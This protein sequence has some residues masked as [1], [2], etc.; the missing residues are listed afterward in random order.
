MSPS[1]YVRQKV[2]NSD[3]AEVNENEDTE[4]QAAGRGETDEGRAER[5][6]RKV[7]GWSHRRDGMLSPFRKAFSEFNKAQMK[8][9]I[10]AFDDCKGK[11]KE[12]I[13]DEAV[14]RKIMDCVGQSYDTLCNANAESFSDV[15]QKYYN[16]KG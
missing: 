11:V 14:V 6:Q 7:S 13:R 9:Q 10:N 16:G 5:A 15:T 8:N 4:S 12:F 1:E 3:V 2:T